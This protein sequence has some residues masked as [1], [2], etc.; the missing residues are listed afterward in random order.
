MLKFYFEVFRTSL[1]LNQTMDLIYI[2][3]H[4]IYWSKVFI[5]TISTHD[6]DLEVEVL[7][8]LKFLFEFLRLQYFLTLSRIWFIFDQI[9]Q[10]FWVKGWGWGGGLTDTMNLVYTVCWG[11]SLSILRITMVVSETDKSCR[12]RIC[13]KEFQ[14]TFFQASILII[15]KFTAGDSQSHILWHCHSDLTSIISLTYGVQRDI[16]YVC[17]EVLSFLL[18]GWYGCEIFLRP[19]WNKQFQYLREL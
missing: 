14:E 17:S 5:S 8:M 1:L 2:W 13:Y 6:H 11:L 18:Y 3:Y 9:Y 16:W 19:L 12:Y 7:K 10:K 15:V 4:D